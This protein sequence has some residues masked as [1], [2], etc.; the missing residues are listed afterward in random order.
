MTVYQ[1]EI[2]AIL[3]CT[4]TMQEKQVKDYNIAI[5]S[6]SKSALLSLRKDCTQSR[7]TYEC[8]KKL[9]HL[10]KNKKNSLIWV[11]DIMFENEKADKLAKTG[12]QGALLG[13]QPNARIS[14]GIVK[15]AKKKWLQNR[16]KL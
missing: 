3:K 14:L 7:I 16:D 13:P 15:H 11:P 5:C 1:A 2:L 6:D 9:S 8:A 4:E 10:A 12:A